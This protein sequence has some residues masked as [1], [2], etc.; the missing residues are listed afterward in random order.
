[1]YRMIPEPTLDYSDLYDEL[2][3][4]GRWIKENTQVVTL[5]D[6][7]LDGEQVRIDTSEGQEYVTTCSPH[8]AKQYPPY[9][10]DGLPKHA[11]VY[12]VRYEY[13]TP[14]EY[15]FDGVQ[16]YTEQFSE[17]GFP[18]GYELI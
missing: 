7:P 13:K 3:K 17:I 10:F 1:M 9:E 16:A 8:I 4:R 6:G 2:I 12:T 14:D 15:V 18:F 5:T 11:D